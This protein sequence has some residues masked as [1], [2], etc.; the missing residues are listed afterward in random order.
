MASDV[1]DRD[2]H[3]RRIVVR[4]GRVDDVVVRPLR[5]T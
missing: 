1:D 3:E 5:L 4:G 2:D